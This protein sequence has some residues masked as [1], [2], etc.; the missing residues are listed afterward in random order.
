M[1][2]STRG[3]SDRARM[4]PAEN[5]RFATGK[6][7]GFQRRGYITFKIFMILIGKQSQKQMFVIMI[8]IF[9]VQKRKCLICGSPF[10][11]KRAQGV[12]SV[13]IEN[14]NEKN[15]VT[16]SSKSETDSKRKIQ[17]GA[18][19]LY[20]FPKGRYRSFSEHFRHPLC[21]N[22]TNFSPAPACRNKA[23]AKR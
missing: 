15:P 19:F 21:R 17:E 6:H 11:E 8:N 16:N 2:L 20:P 22:K 3:G 7:A 5:H 14:R 13:K 18:N 1:K 12:G 23:G 10:L 9:G 4:T